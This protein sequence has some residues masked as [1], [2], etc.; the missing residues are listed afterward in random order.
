MLPKE[1]AELWRVR[2]LETARWRVAKTLSAI[3]QPQVY[4]VPGYH[5]ARQ[6]QDAVMF[7][8]DCTRLLYA[9]CSSACDSSRAVQLACEVFA[10]GSWLTGRFGQ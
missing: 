7:T 8:L 4:Q 6:H 10:R 1:R 9:T 3:R 5:A 2:L